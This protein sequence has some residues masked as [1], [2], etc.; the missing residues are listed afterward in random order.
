MPA[1]QD[2][3]ISLG[4][5]AF[6]SWALRCY[7]W[8]DLLKSPSKRGSNRVIAGEEGRLARVRVG[9][10]LRAGLRFR[11]SGRWQHPSG[12]PFTGDPHENMYD[13]LGV[14]RGVCDEP[15]VQQLQLVGV[16][17]SSVDCIVEEMGPPRFE[18]PTVATLVVDVTLPD[19][20]VDL[21]GGS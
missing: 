17:G 20:P 19:G 1:L 6:R 14:L 8:S 3:Y 16:M 2:I 11:V 9:D 10:E 21:G 18:S 4:G 5:V 7:D 15:D 12:D 13:L